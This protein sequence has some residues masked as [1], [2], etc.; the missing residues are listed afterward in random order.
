MNR[1]KLNEKV[2]SQINIPLNEENEIIENMYLFLIRQKGQDKTLKKSTLKCGICRKEYSKNEILKCK[3][4]NNIKCFECAKK[5]NFN[6]A[7]IDH[8]KYICNICIGVEE[9]ERYF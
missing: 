2:H 9:K 3:L 5:F 1:K 7:K 6:E 8:N 4:C